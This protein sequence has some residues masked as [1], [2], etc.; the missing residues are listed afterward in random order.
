MSHEFAGK[1][2][3]DSECR[4]AA[5]FDTLPRRARDHEAAIHTTTTLAV[6]IA[7]IVRVND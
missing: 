3:R 5:T 1:Y 6:L 7:V 4:P 2:R